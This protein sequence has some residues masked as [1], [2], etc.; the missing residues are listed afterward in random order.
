[1]WASAEGE[2]GTG[3]QGISS[4]SEAGGTRACVAQLELVDVGADYS[5]AVG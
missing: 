4:R 1:M 2:H 3:A 5:H